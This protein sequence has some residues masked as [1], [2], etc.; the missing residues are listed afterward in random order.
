VRF[1]D[2]SFWIGLMYVR[3]QR[4]DAAERLWLAERHDRVSTSLVIGETWIFLSR[5]LGHAMV[6]RFVSIAET[7]PR[8]RIVR[9][10]ADVARE[11]WAWLRRHVERVNSFVDAAGF[12]TVRQLGRT[13]ALAFDGDFSAAG[14]IEVRP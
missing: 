1:V 2:T 11:V 14:F 12:A 3:D 6:I 7:S 10:D 4:H 8:L 13:E 9:V 5:R